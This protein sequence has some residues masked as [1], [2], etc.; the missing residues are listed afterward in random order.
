MT[1]YNQLTW[2]GDSALPRLLSKSVEWY[3]PTLYIKAAREVMNGI[4]E[5][6]PA[7]CEIANRVVQASRYY[8][9]KIN[10]LLQPWKARSLWLNPPYGRGDGNR[11]NQEIWTCKL[12]AEYEAGNVEEAI[13]LV[14]AATDTGWFQ[15][16]WRYSICFVKQRIDFYTSEGSL[17]GPTHGSV[18]VYFGPR[19]ERFSEVFSQFGHVIPGEPTAPGL[20]LWEA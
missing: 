19:T 11:S 20:S 4:I 1:Q 7:S 2:S 9:I 14:N 3:T 17:G 12:I 10:G 8:D 15:R 5:L 13:L 6:D 16:L 18:F